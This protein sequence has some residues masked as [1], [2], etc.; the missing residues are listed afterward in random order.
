MLKLEGKLDMLS[1]KGY[2]RQDADCPTTQA[3]AIPNCWPPSRMARQL[4]RKCLYG[5][6]T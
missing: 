2:S 3:L 4:I 1:E 6:E 5:L